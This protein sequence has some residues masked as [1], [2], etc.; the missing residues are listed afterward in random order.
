MRKK[1]AV[2]TTERRDDSRTQKS[3]LIAK[4]K[5]IQQSGTTKCALDNRSHRTTLRLSCRGLGTSRFMFSRSVDLSIL[6]NQ[7]NC[8]RLTA[9]GAC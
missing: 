6:S 9:S 8:T 5:N 2:Q 3:G 7:S 4:R 1:T